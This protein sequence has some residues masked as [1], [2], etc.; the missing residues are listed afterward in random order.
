MSVSFLTYIPGSHT[1]NLLSPQAKPNWAGILERVVGNDPTSSR[2]QRG[3][4]PLYY[5]RISFIISL[6]ETTSHLV[7]ISS[8]LVFGMS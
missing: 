3:V 4:I 6:L 7:V 2:W 1:V 5:T 8:N